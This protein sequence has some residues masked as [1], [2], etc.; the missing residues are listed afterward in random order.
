MV[1]IPAMMPNTLSYDR[2]TWNYAASDASGKPVPEPHLVAAAAHST[3]AAPA[4]SMPARPAYDLTLQHPQLRFPASAQALLA[5]HA[6][7]GGDA[8]PVFRSEQFLKAADLFTSIRKDGDTKKVGTIIYAVGWTQHT[9]GTQTIRTAAMLQ[10]LLG[11]VGR[12]GGGVNALR[13]HSNIQGATDMAGIFDNLPGYLKVPK[14]EDGSFE[15]WMKRVTPTASKP[16]PW[17]SFN[18][19]CNTPKFAVSFLKAMYG[20][21]ATKQNQ[22]AYDYLPKVDRNYSWTYIWDNMYNGVVKGL[23]DV[24]N[25]R[26]GHRPGF[27]K[28]YRRAEKSGLAGRG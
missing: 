4:P 15:G 10:L 21:A 17:E 8:S 16:G 19:W 23:F 24:R 12:A 18:Y 6:G 25:E 28:K 14:P 1:S 3:A 27:E 13:G 7:N 5:L 22:W 2:A 11:N 9:S 26:R 20:D